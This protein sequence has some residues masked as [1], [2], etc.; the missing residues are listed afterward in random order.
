[1]K[2]KILTRLKLT[3][4]MA[5]LVVSVAFIAGAI[6]QLMGNNHIH[7]VVYVMGVLGL[8]WLGLTFY[9]LIDGEKDRQ[10]D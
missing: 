6:D 8:G 7:W 1:M 10:N 3:A 2:N 5:T 9:C 4:F